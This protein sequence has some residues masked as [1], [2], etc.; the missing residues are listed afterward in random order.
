MIDR[1]SSFF[2]IGEVNPCKAS[3]IYHSIGYLQLGSNAHNH[4]AAVGVALATSI[5]TKVEANAAVDIFKPTSTIIGEVLFEDLKD[6]PCP[7]LLKPRCIASSQPTPLATKAK[8]PSRP[9][10]QIPVQTRAGTKPQASDVC[11]RLAAGAPCPSQIE[12]YR[13]NFQ[14]LPTHI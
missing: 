8:R 4:P 1:K 7:C 6:I 3:V 5:A 12:E 13:R 2:T 14:A 11:H 10:R 9:S